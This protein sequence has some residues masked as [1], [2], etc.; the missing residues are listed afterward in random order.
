MDIFDLF[1]GEP[2]IWFAFGALL[3]TIDLMLI[4]A[5]VFLFMALSA[6]AMVLVSMVFP[7]ISFAVSAV[8]F[9]VFCFLSYVLV[10][11]FVRKRKP[12]KNVCYSNENMLNSQFTLLDDLEAGVKKRIKINHI[13]Y[14]VVSNVDQERGRK[15]MVYKVDNGILHVSSNIPSHEFPRENERREEKR[16][17]PVPSP[18]YDDSPSTAN[19]SVDTS[20]GGGE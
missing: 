8:L 14:T 3:L 6:F 1:L 15:L 5:P 9:S 12:I 11:D 4:G 10:Q 19:T 20:C 7:N 2:T 17:E 16:Q 13:H 18:H